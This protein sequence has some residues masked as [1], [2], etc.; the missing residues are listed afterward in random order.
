MV[1]ESSSPM[2][3]WL[4]QAFVGFL[5]CHRSTGVVIYAYSTLVPCVFRLFVNLSRR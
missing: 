4:R 1:S 3:V 5:Y 2:L